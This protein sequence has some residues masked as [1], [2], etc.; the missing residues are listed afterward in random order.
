MLD[1]FAFRW[2]THEQVDPDIHRSRQTL[3]FQALIAAFL[4]H[5]SPEAARP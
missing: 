4:R 3:E 5:Y 2:N 1:A